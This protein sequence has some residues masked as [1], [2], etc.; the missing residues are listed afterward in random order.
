[1]QIIL[2]FKWSNVIKPAKHKP[3]FKIEKLTEEK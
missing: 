2:N 3:F 1:M